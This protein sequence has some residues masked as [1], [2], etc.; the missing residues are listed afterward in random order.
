[1]P[2]IPSESIPIPD[3]SKLKKLTPQEFIETAPLYQSIAIVDFRAPESITRMC[4]SQKC[5]R[6]TTWLRMDTISGG[7]PKAYLTGLEFRGAAYRCGLCKGS[8]IAVLYQLLFWA[9]SGQIYHHYAVRKIGQM[10]QSLPS[11]PNELSKRLGDTANYYKKALASREQNYGIGAMAYMRRVVDDKTDE[12][13]D[14]MA[15]LAQTQGIGKD[16]VKKILSAKSAI[17]YEEKLRVASE[18]I[19][20]VLRP[21]GVNPL[22]QLYGHTSESL[23][24]K[25][26]E[27][28]VGIFD[29]L[30]ADFEY[31]FQNL[32]REAEERKAYVE[33]MGKRAGSKTKEEK[34]TPQDL[35]N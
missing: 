10:P 31:I 4:Y 29:D 18:L 27:E 14:V 21:G 11:I 34:E 24:D 12:L 17:R 26:D 8:G 35:S 3:T 19:P 13:I 28:C 33:R 5:K 32:H 25:T 6:E 16:E 7:F 23:H 15:E 1:M 22:G 2:E 20:D 9:G 30:K